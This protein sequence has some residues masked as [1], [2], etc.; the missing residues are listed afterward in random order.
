MKSRIESPPRSMMEVYKNLPEGTLER[1][2]VQ[3]DIIVVLKKNEKI[4]NKR[5]HIHGVP[6]LL[7]EILS[8]G[9]EEHDLVRKKKLYERFGVKEYWVIDPESKVDTVFS[10]SSGQIHKSIRTAQEDYFPDFKH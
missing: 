4:I 6:D 9:N 5:G 8:E 1:N 2:A 10:L 7:V 3:P